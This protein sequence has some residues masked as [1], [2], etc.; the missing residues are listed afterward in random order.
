MD[1]T[2]LGVVTSNSSETVSLHKIINIMWEYAKFII[3][4]TLYA[5]W[6]P[7]ADNQKTGL[8]YIEELCLF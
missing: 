2:S 1:C 6:S 7:N 3:K 4:E 5:D 8:K